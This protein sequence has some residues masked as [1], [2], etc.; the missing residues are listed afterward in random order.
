MVE[1][2]FYNILYKMWALSYIWFP[3]DHLHALI[4]F[5]ILLSTDKKLYS[6]ID[7]KSTAVYIEL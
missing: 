7:S 1:H 2:V 3:S 5:K 4:E 6:R